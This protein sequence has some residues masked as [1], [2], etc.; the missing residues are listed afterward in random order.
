MEH[1][2]VRGQQVVVDLAVVQEVAGQREQVEH[3][4]LAEHQEIAEV[5]DQVVLQVV[6]EVVVLR[7]L[8]DLAEHQV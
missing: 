4:E 7:G 5:P 3:Q 8:Q 1:Q 6:V 2:E